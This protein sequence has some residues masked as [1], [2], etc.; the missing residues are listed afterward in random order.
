MYIGMVHEETKQKQNVTEKSKQKVEPKKKQTRFI[1][2][3]WKNRKG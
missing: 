1:E 2:K 3:E